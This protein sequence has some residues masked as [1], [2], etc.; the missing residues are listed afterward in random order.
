MPKTAVQAQ[1]LAGLHTK[2]ERSKYI[3]M[4]TDQATETARYSVQSNESS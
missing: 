1:E 4:T 3:R 2:K